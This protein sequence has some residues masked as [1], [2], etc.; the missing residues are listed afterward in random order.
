VISQR[1]SSHGPLLK[2]FPASHLHDPFFM[3]RRRANRALMTS[4]PDAVVKMWT[5]RIR[6]SDARYRNF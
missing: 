6:K 4:T 3:F 5:S 1:S 2:R